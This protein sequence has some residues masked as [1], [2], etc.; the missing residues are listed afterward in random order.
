MRAYLLITGS[1]F[2]LLGA[3]HI[4]RDIAERQHWSDPGYLIEAA[5]GVVA[6][7]LCAWAFRLLRVPQ[8]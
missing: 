2:G 1:L 4:W 7:A 6:L 8:H 5:T 3:V